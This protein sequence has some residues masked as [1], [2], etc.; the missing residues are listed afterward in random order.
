M[1]REVSSKKRTSKSV[2]RCRSIS[3]NALVSSTKLQET[4]SVK[5]RKPRE[6][7]EFSLCVQC[8]AWF[9]LQYA[10]REMWHVPNG[11]KRNLL[12]AVKFKQMGVKKG[13]PDYI[14]PEPVAPYHGLFVEFKTEK[15]RE[16]IEQL[17]LMHK[18][19]QKNY[20]VAVVRSFEQFQE[21]VRRYF[22]D[23]W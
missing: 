13:V 16:S 21:V 14:F 19:E 9:S 5:L 12:E 17:Q 8:Y 3:E 18:L 20:F 23:G 15:T 1:R 7:K 4:S 11:G 22:K 2:F 6:A 10:K